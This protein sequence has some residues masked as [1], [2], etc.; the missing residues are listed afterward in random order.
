VTLK[1]LGF[2]LILFAALQSCKPMDDA[3]S[4]L[5]WGVHRS[6]RSANLLNLLPNQS[7]EV[8]AD[9]QDWVAAGQEA[10]QK[11][12]TAIDRWGH[13]KVVPCGQTADLTINLKGFGSAGLNYFT[14][15]PGRI[16]LKSSA[17]GNFLRAVALHE[18]GH[19]YGLCD[20]YKDAG[21]SNCS[22][23]RSER[24]Q[25]EEVMGATNARKINL[26]MGDIE[27][28]RKAASDMSIRANSRW[29]SYL[30]TANK[31]PLPQPN[32][33]PSNP[34]DQQSNQTPNI[35]PRKVYATLLAGSSSDRP[36]L[37]FS[38][39]SGASV[40]ICK[41]QF[42]LTSC[43]SQSQQRLSVQK[44]RSVADRD[45]YVS[46]NDISVTSGN[47]AFVVTLKDSNGTKTEKFRIR[48][49]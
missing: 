28:V 41:Y 17:S 45:I 25:N 18:F 2:L 4:R 24:Q 15:R 35:L 27:G 38:V 21:S 37:A 48:R 43:N 10:I 13:M 16:F 42:G 3:E 14:A 20:Q 11:W 47:Q 23:A 30:L 7:V 9:K 36:K 32:T 33:L 19:S 31:N 12:A 1:S 6:A 46:S 40:A 26:T 5:Q 34:Q 44:S 49:R 29:Q 22:D 39:P 8:C